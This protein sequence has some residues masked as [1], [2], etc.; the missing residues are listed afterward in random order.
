MHL[1]IYLMY[2]SDCVKIIILIISDS[3]A[4]IYFYICF[5]GF[6][7]LF[8]LWHGLVFKN[9]GSVSY[10]Q[11]CVRIHTEYVFKCSLILTESPFYYILK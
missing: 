2:I 4:D 11:W 6:F 3:M 8:Y 9:P 5:L 1:F 10:P 7:F